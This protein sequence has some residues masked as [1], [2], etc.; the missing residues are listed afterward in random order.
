[1]TYFNVF[2]YSGQNNIPSFLRK[3][4]AR[5]RSNSVP[6]KKF[7]SWDKDIVCLPHDYTDV[8]DVMITIPRGKTRSLLA[9]YNLFGKI[10]LISSMTEKEIKDEIR[11]VFHKQMKPD[12]DFNFLQSTGGGT[13]MLMAPQVSTH[14]SWSAQQ[15]VSLAGQGAIYIQATEPLLTPVVCNGCHVFVDGLRGLNVVI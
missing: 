1:M 2:N 15:V 14:F 9:E 8:G 4:Q 5:Q 6:D 11:S 7:K 3:R 13:K 10:H 12:H